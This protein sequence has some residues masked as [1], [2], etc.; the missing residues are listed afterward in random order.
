[1]QMSAALWLCLRLIFR[2]IVPLQLPLIRGLPAV[3]LTG[4]CRATSAVP[5]LKESLSNMIGT[6]LFARVR[7]KRL[8][9]LR[10]LLTRFVTFFLHRISISAVMKHLKLNGKN[11]LAVKR[12]LRITTLRT[13]KICRVGLITK[14]LK[15]LAQRVKGLSVGMK[16]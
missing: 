16:F 13:R 10:V 9:L 8:I 2:L 7:T 3:S 6:G 12:E 5:F 15:Q 11:A 1:M 14:C 4:M